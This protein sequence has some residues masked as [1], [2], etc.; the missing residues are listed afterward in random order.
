MRQNVKSCFA[1]A[2]PLKYDINRCYLGHTRDMTLVN[3]K[4][5]LLCCP[6]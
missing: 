1:D 6:F 3:T 2:S 5:W 4:P